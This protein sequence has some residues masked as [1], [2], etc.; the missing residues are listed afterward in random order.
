M[1]PS[2]CSSPSSTSWPPCPALVVSRPLLSR[3][4]LRRQE[5]HHRAA[6][7]SCT[8]SLPRRRTVHHGLPAYEQQP[9]SSDTCF[10]GRRYDHHL[11]AIEPHRSC[12]TASPIGDK[13]HGSDS[14]HRPTHSPMRVTY[15]LAHEHLRKATNACAQ[16]HPPGDT[17]PTGAQMTLLLG[18][19]DTRSTAHKRH[20]LLRCDPYCMTTTRSYMLDPDSLEQIA[21]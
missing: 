2:D 3:F 15:A 14:T 17:C 12:Y 20:L 6:H 7:N 8:D 4:E 21:N 18:L 13:R 10:C 19:G 9:D 1:V 16:M 5:L 11:H